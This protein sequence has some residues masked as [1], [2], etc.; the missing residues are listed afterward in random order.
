MDR[1]IRESLSDFLLYLELMLGFAVLALL[2]ACTGTYGV[3]SFLASSRDREFAIRSALGAGQKEVAR[4]VL[5]D[6]IR[7]TATGLAGGMVIVLI[8]RSVLS[9]LPVSVHGPDVW[10]TM[11]VAVAISVLTIS[12]CWIPARRAATSDPMTALRKD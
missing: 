12:A 5:R 10:T 7:L 8:G 11:P 6:A 2:L 4:L 1:V 3:I 9:N